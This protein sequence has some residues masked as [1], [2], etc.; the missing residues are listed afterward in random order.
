M[1]AISTS[2]TEKDITNIATV[3]CSYPLVKSE[4]TIKAEKTMGVLGEH[5][6]S[7]SYQGITV[8]KTLSV[9]TDIKELNA[10]QTF[11][12]TEYDDSYPG[13]HTED[14]VRSVN[15]LPSDKEPEMS[16]VLYYHIP[17]DASYIG[18]DLEVK[19]YS[20]ESLRLR[21]TELE[22]NTFSP[23][24]DNS[25]CPSPFFTYKNAVFD[26]FTDSYGSY[27]YHFTPE[28]VVYEGRN[29]DKQTINYLGSPLCYWLM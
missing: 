4:N 16:C 29:Y 9:T 19:Y 23:T 18:T 6:I 10:Y 3:N 22:R 21:D 15:A 1:T 27:S 5:E 25:S 7:A 26:G 28:I 14:H 20:G 17:D 8:H 24:L 11:R 12:W 13:G 2:G